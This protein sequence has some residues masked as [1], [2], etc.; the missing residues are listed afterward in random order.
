MRAL[1]LRPTYPG[2]PYL[3][4]RMRGSE[5]PRVLY[6]RPLQGKDI[7]DSVQPHSVESRCGAVAAVKVVGHHQL[8]GPGRFPSP[9]LRFHIPLIGRVEDW[10]A[11]LRRRWVFQCFRTGRSGCHRHVSSPRH[12]KRSLRIS[13][14]PLPCV[15]RI[16]GYGTYQA[17]SAFSDEPRRTR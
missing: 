4:P 16:K 2:T 7:R 8:S 11:D 13:R 12:V 6:L 1:L 3:T 9:P 17:G 10:R 15:L 5:P 14:T